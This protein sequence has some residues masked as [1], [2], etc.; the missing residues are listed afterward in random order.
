MDSVGLKNE[1]AGMRDYTGQSIRIAGPVPPMLTRIG[2][3]FVTEQTQ[4]PCSV[5]LS[6]FAFQHLYQQRETMTTD[7]RTNA[8]R[9]DQAHISDATANNMTRHECHDELLAFV[10]ALTMQ[11][12]VSVEKVAQLLEHSMKDAM[13][14]T[15]SLIEDQMRLDHWD[16]DL[17]DGETLDELAG[18]AQRFLETPEGVRLYNHFARIYARTTGEMFD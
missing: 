1:T 13:T 10:G 14:A 6:A 17:A 16:A 12:P 8:P 5:T 3:V 7:P 15:I 4:R 11:R 18:R 9:E 2:C